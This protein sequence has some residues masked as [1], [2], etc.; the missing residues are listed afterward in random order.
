MVELTE[1]EVLGIKI[2]AMIREGMLDMFKCSVCSSEMQEQRN[3]LLKED[4]ETPV[5]AH[6]LIGELYMCPMRMI[7]TSIYD[8]LDEFD[9]LEKSQ[10]NNADNYKDVNPRFWLATKQ[11]EQ[12]KYE[13]KQYNDKHKPKES[14]DNLSKMAGLFN[15]GD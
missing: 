12:F 1:I 13:L 5:F 4:F 3:C 15:K 6:P 11:Y 10:W 14:E 2:I 8:W 7:P 9:Y